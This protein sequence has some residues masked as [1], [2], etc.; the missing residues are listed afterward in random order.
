MLRRLHPVAGITAFVIILLF[1]S[2]TVISE[3]FG[4]PAAVA[5]VKG[6]I[7]WGMLL[8]IPSL[9]FAG[10]SGFRIG[11]RSPHRLIARKRKRMP[12]IAANGILILVPSAFFLAA[13]ADAG[14]FDTTFYLVQA[15]ELAAGAVNLTLIG[16]SIRDGFGLT[17]RFR[18]RPVRQGPAQ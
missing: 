10:A 16:L 15:L 5:A 6:A 14:E 7:L 12:F 8:L 13:R 17:G 1:W 2:S 11:G 3:L 9:A 18:A 4:T